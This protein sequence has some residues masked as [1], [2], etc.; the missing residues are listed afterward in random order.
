[1]N[2]LAGPARDIARATPE[3]LRSFYSW[4]A[5]N[6]GDVTGRGKKPE[7]HF[8]VLCIPNKHFAIVHTRGQPLGRRMPS[9]RINGVAGAGKGARDFLCIEIVFTHHAIQRGAEKFPVRN[10]K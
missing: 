8:T 5:R 4:T 7:L 6:P 2:V 10:Q 9:Q 3:S 1:D